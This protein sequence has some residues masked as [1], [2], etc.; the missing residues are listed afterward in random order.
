MK[1]QRQST[2]FALL[3]E[4]KEATLW[5]WLGFQVED[6]LKTSVVPSRFANRRRC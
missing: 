5:C 2:R 6:L 1:I 3:L 4:T